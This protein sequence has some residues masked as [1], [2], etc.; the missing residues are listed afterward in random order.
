M[1]TTTGA[2]ALR[3]Y[4]VTSADGTA[5]RAW[6][7]DVDG[8]T[9]V[10]CNG[11]GTNAYAWP[12]LL[13]PDCGVHV[14]SWNHRG[15][16]GSARPDDEDRVGVDAFAEDAL[17]VMDDAGL[18]R[19]VVMGWSLGVNAAF[20]LAVR[21]PERVTG[22]FAVAGVPGGTFASM[23]GP[24]RVPPPLRHPITVG[25]ATLLRGTG[26]LISPLTRRL[27]IGRISTTALRHSGFMLPRADHDVTSEAVREFLTTDV[28]WYFHLAVEASQHPRVS[29][30]QIAVPTAFV[31][32]RYDVLAGRHEI[33]TAA[34]RIE[35]AVLT[36]LAGSHFVQL[37]YPDEVHDALLD[38]LHRV[39]A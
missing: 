33:H 7:N 8:P 36:E 37:E 32:G 10:L 29:L 9:V 21:H 13:E 14:V 3:F 18:E 25:A 34:A 12:A 23:L 1:T 2:R 6:T 27:P 20:E 26:H 31:A 15:V 30:T 4:D 5:L 22:L 11:L 35:G 38:L 17:A 19:G 24:L 16:G 39:D 28:D